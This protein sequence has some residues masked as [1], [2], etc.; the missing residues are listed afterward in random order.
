MK[1]P[2]CVEFERCFDLRCKAKQGYMLTTEDMKFLMQMFEKY[3]EW[4]KSL[5]SDIFNRTAPF[6]SRQINNKKD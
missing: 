1:Q 5:N 3:P 4:Y 2:S 6:G